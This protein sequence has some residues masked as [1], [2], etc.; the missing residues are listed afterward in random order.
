M[1]LVFTVDSIEK[2]GKSKDKSNSL[3][4]HGKKFGIGG[5]R[6]K[7]KSFGIKVIKSSFVTWILLRF[8]YSIIK[9]FRQSF[10]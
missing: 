10:V 8:P 2:D 4:A 3:P 1:K 5:K 9:N 7:S 6:L